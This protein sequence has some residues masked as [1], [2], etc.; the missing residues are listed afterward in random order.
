[1]TTTCYW[2]DVKVFE[3]IFLLLLFFRDYQMIFVCVADASDLLNRAHR[4]SYDDAREIQIRD[5]A[6][7]RHRYPLSCWNEI[8]R[9]FC[10]EGDRFQLKCLKS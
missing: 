6:L 7:T 2:I 4:N 3:F 9:L 8:L 10:D 1:M 5:D